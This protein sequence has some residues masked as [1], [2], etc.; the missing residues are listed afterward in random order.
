LETL[1]IV[2]IS[3]KTETALWF[4]CDIFLKEMKQ[5]VYSLE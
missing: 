4:Q 2:E 3:L 1:K 5:K